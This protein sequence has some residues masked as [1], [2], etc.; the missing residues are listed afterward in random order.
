LN[1]GSRGNM[2]DGSNYKVTSLDVAE[3]A[4]IK[5]NLNINQ[6]LDLSD[7]SFDIVIMDQILEHLGTCDEIIKEVK[8]VT[9][10]YF[11]VFIWGWFPKGI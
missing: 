1:I 7:D 5:Q 6:K 4:D 2:L 8:M 9:K 3:N 10:K 11:L